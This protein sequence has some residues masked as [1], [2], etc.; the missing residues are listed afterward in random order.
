MTTPAESSWRLASFVAFLLPMKALLFAVV[1]GFSTA[2]LQA[3]S[4]LAETAALFAAQ[5]GDP[6]G[7]TQAER[8]QRFI[9]NSNNYAASQ[10]PIARLQR[11][12]A[13]EQDAI[14]RQA[15][16]DDFDQRMMALKLEQIERE[17][18]VEARRKEKMIEDAK[19]RAAAYP[20]DNGNGRD[21]GS[22]TEKL[23]AA[24]E[25]QTRAIEAAT[26]SRQPTEA[27]KSQ[28]AFFT[29]WEAE[30]KTR[31][32]EDAAERRHQES[33]DA[34]KDIEMTLQSRGRGR[35]YDKDR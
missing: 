30:R 29:E 18:D 4:T 8:Y 5:P 33:L 9:D 19:V 17:N 1:V 22:D 2:G 31:S 27:K 21:T 3:G 32:A 16:N 23:I 35:D 12:D 34:V 7:E 10:A 24:I 26:A 13:L 11:Q 20:T 15:A 25:A 14:R 6:A 28:E